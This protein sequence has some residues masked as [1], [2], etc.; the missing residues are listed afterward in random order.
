MNTFNIYNDPRE[1]LAKEIYQ[2]SEQ[3]QMEYTT[4]EDFMNSEDFEFESDR[5]KWV[6][7]KIGHMKKQKNKLTRSALPTEK[8]NLQDKKQ[9]MN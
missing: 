2:N 8:T 6:K 9:S 4:W 3:Y 5:L 1:D 7:L